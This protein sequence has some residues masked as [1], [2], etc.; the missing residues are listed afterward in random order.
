MPAHGV[1]DKYEIEPFQVRAYA[2]GLKGASVDAVFAQY[3]LKGRVPGLEFITPLG[4]IT[5]LYVKYHVFRDIVNG[6][7]VRWYSVVYRI[8]AD[9]IGIGRLVGD[10]VAELFIVNE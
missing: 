3:G 10:F 7:V 1:H 2:D 4:C 6:P 5:I 8:R 9:G